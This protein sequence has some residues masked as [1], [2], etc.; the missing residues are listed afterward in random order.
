MARRSDYFLRP[1]ALSWFFLDEMARQGHKQIVGWRTSGYPTRGRGGSPQG[2]EVL[3]AAGR[4]LS[5]AAG[6]DGK[7]FVDDVTETVTLT[8]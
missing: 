4:I 8:E 6:P 7:V 5:V 2:V 1:T 3:T